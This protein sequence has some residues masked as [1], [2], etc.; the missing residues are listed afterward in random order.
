MA[1]QKINGISLYFHHTPGTVLQNDQG[2]RILVFCLHGYLDHG[3]TFNPLLS[4]LPWQAVAWDARG[5]GQSEW[6][7]AY[8]YYHFYDYLR[9]LH[10]ALQFQLLATQ[11]TQALLIGHSM[12]GMIAS[13]YAGIYPEKIAGLIN[14]EGWMIPDS[15]PHQVPQRL[16][17]WLEQCGEVDNIRPFARHKTREEAIARMQRQDPLLTP[18]QIQALSEP[19][20]AH[21]DKG[22]FWRH[23]PLHRTRS[24]QP[25]RLDQAQACWQGITAPQLLLYGEQSP[26]LKLPDWTERMDSFG[27]NNPERDTTL[28]ALEQAG[29]NL[30]L[31]QSKAIAKMLGHWLRMRPKFKHLPVA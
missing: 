14:L 8:D 24:P 29:H 30:H 15:D 9:D 22:F 16:R 23:D 20:L 5:F 25:F 10:A 11:S 17:Q 1:Y 19:I 18:E 3:G 6:I 28:V 7:P 13:L 2:Q 27:V 31:H 4:H 12:G 21:D 26:I